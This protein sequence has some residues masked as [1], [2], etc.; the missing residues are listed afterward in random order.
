MNLNL[1]LFRDKKT[2]QIS[3]MADT[4]YPGITFTRLDGALIMD[5]PESRKVLRQARKQWGIGFNFGYGLMYDVKNSKIV[6][7]PYFGVG[8]NYTPKFLQW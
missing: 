7:G 1:G 8:L 5:D 2:K 6:N 3:I 4:D